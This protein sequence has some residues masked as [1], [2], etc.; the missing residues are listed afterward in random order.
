MHKYNIMNRRD[1]LKRIGIISTAVVVLPSIVIAAESTV[2][3]IANESLHTAIFSQLDNSNVHYYNKLTLSDIE[4][5]LNDIVEN[6]DFTW[7]LKGMNR[8][9]LIEFDKAVKESVNEWR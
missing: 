6:K 9:Q 1:F 8:R 4:E 5:C 3:V 7:Q 2:Q